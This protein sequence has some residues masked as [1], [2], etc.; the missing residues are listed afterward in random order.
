MSVIR[1]NTAL[2]QA[3]RDGS[4]TQTRRLM[5]P[6]PADDETPVAGSYHVGERLQAV[7]QLTHGHTKP[8]CDIEITAVR[9]ERLESISDEDIAAEGFA[10]WTQFAHFWS[11]IYPQA[12]VVM[13]PWV[14][15]YS[16]KRV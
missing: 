3:V 8:I 12:P 13:N 5:V 9:W 4:K 6:Q 14:F 10:N 16:F 1:F 11:D 2:A 7:E 15:V